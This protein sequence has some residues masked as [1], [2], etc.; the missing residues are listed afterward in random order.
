LMISPSPGERLAA[1]S[2]VTMKPKPEAIP[3][4]AERIVKEAPFIGYHSAIALRAAIR[5]LPDQKAELRDAIDRGLKALE[6][7]PHTDRYK[8]LQRA[9]RELAKLPD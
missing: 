8:E 5:A 3:W 7:K 9:H 6:K 1:V 2:V 4:L